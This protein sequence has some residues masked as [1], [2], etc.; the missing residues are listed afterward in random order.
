MK[1]KKRENKTMTNRQF[2]AVIRMIIEMVMDNVP[3]ETLLKYLN[4]LIK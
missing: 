3:K 2:Q 1:K 4:I